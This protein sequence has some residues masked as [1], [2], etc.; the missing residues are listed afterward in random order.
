[1][2]SRVHSRSQCDATAQCAHHLCGIL[3][4]VPDARPAVDG[5]GFR[6]EHH[7]QRLALPGSRVLRRPARK[8]SRFDSQARVNK[9]TCKQDCLFRTAQD[10]VQIG[11]SHKHKKGM[12]ASDITAVGNSTAQDG[13]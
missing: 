5:A 7:G 8:K 11:V 13:A 3:A 4:Q 1:M 10:G 12:Q 6:H 9:P 2:H